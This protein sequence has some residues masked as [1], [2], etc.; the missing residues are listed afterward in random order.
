VFNLNFVP[1]FK[2]K[3]PAPEG[4]AKKIKERQYEYNH[5]VGDNRRD[6]V[7]FAGLYPAKI[8]NFYLTERFLS[9]DKQ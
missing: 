3:P 9:G 7:S 2:I 4:Q 5:C 8:G 1:S 6:M